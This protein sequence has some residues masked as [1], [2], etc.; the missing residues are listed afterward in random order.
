[1]LS[2]REMLCPHILRQSSFEN[3]SSCL[4]YFDWIHFLDIDGERRHH[5]G[6]EA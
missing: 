3:D 6:A 5:A 1:M 2:I 4:L